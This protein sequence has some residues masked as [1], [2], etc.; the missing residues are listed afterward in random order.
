MVDLEFRL[1]VLILINEGLDFVVDKE[2]F[3]DEEWNEE[4]RQVGSFL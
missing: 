1:Q 3:W 2:L 4:F